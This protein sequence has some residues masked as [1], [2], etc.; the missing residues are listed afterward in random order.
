M[1]RWQG[2]EPSEHRTPIVTRS[3]IAYVTR[4]PKAAWR[5]TSSSTESPL[6][7]RHAPTQSSTRRS[8]TF[9]VTG[10]ANG[11]Q[12]GTAPCAR[13]KPTP[14]CCWSRSRSPSRQSQR[15]WPSPCCGARWC[16]SSSCSDTGAIRTEAPG[17][18]PLDIGLHRLAAHKAAADPGCRD[19]GN[20]CQD[21]LFSL[22]KAM[23]MA[24]AI[25]LVASC[26]GYN[27]GGEP[28]GVGPATA[29]SMVLNLPRVT[30]STC[31]VMSDRRGRF[32]CGPHSERPFRRGPSS[33]S[34]QP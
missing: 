12:P 8:P 3:S 6:R 4:P 23:S 24:T 1:H 30:S 9:P 13:S 34:P 31:A 18:A 7:S 25:V 26:Y 20:G 28:V 14:R 33:L 17:R 22:I 21:F 10:W 15:W 32:V 11:A 2:A 29:K 27:A 5:R 16:L 19:S